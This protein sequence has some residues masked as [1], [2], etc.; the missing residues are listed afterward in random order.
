M[1]W[2]NIYRKMEN[3]MTQCPISLL[4][5]VFMGYFPTHGR[6]KTTMV[7]SLSK[8]DTIFKITCGRD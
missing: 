4:V 6:W 5:I 1:I 2:T 8:N 7:L 3:N